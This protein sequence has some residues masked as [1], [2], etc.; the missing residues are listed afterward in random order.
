MEYR[1]GRSEA[2]DQGNH[3]GRNAGLTGFSRKW[4]VDSRF[5]P[6]RDIMHCAMHGSKVPIEA[7]EVSAY[8]IPTDFPEADGTFSWNRTTLVLVRATAA[9]KRGLGYTYAD[10]ATGRL[11]SDSLA[12][13]P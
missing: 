2:E 12:G 6:V 3:L 4:L 5:Q 8:S 11:I 9:G 10:I 7:V 13:S 1:Q